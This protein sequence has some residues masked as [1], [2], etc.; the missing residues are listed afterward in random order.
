MIIIEG[1]T[2]RIYINSLKEL[3]KI[4]EEN[5]PLE[6]I[7]IDKF[8]NYL[9]N[10]NIHMKDEEII[11]KNFDNKDLNIKNVKKQLA[12]KGNLNQSK[13]RYTDLVLKAH[14][15]LAIRE[16]GLMKVN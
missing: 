4:G 3:I 15:E 7:N 14:Q 10:K 8:C 2:P 16:T 9:R 6:A 5:L 1:S 12:K 13:Q 11:L